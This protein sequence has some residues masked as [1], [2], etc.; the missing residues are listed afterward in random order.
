MVNF[1][2]TGVL[3]KKEKPIALLNPEFIF[4]LV[5]LQDRNPIKG[6]LRMEAICVTIGGYARSHS[7]YL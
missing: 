2:R 1:T 7:F 6:F 3:K 4:E 5:S